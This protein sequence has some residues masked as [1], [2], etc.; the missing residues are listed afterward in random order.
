MW[1]SPGAVEYHD[2]VVRPSTKLRLGC[3]LSR[4]KLNHHPY[5]ACRYLNRFFLIIL[6]VVLSVIFLIAPMKNQGLDVDLP[7]TATTSTNLEDKPIVV[8]IDTSGKISLENTPVVRSVLRQQLSKYRDEE[9]KKPIFLEADKS[10]AYETVVAIM[11]DIKAAGFD[12]LRMV[13]EPDDRLK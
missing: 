1:L 12:K 3:L 2:I 4:L 7:E 6:F 10:V 8:T 5:I 11:A 13:T 9:K